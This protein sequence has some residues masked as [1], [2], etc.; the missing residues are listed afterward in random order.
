MS[1]NKEF[2]RVNI[3]DVKPLIDEFNAKVPE[4]E[5][6]DYK[7]RQFPKDENGHQFTFLKKKSFDDY[8]EDNDVKIIGAIRGHQTKYKYF[9][10]INKHIKEKYDN[11]LECID[12]K[13]DDKI[14][15]VADLYSDEK[16]LRKFDVREAKDKH[17]YG[18]AWIGD[19]K[20]LEITR[21]DVLFF[22]IP[23]LLALILAVCLASCPKN[24]PPSDI[25]INTGEEV[26][27]E[28]ND[29]TLPEAPMVYYPVFSEVTKL[30]AKDKDI[31]L[32]NH[33]L[34][35]D[36]FYI[37]YSIF[38]YNEDKSKCILKLDS[39]ED[40]AADTVNSYDGSFIAPDE[41]RED[42]KAVAKPVKYNLYDKLDAGTYQLEVVGIAYDY[43]I[44]NEALEAKTSSEQ[45][46]LISEAQQANPAKLITTLVIEK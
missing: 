20:W 31:E 18:Y 19:D 42:G 43:D 22:I 24:D 8:R 11:E 23:L 46:K 14:I 33:A 41:V 44:I 36:K 38:V 1:K 30:D 28:Q 27:E 6:K 25:P 5:Q 34:N 40:F 32:Y 37:A 10:D 2:L 39:P 29:D 26:T 12:K 7:Y 13:Q 4:D 17:V 9:T 21:I 3:K 35:A 15:G 45:Q 16:V